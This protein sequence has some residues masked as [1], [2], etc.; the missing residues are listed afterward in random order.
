MVETIG[1]KY[2]PKAKNLWITADS[3]GSNGY[4][5]RGWKYWL[6]QFAK[7]TGVCEIT[8]LAFSSS[9]KQMEQNRTPDAFLLLV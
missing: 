2:Y 9:H 6:N 1:Q 4:R 5:N 3:G 8:V 7:E